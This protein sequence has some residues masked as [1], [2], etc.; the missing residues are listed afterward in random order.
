MSRTVDV[1][2]E[3]QRLI[4]DV[5]WSKEK[6]FRDRH[7]N[8]IAFANGEACQFCTVGA[9]IKANGEGY[10]DGRFYQSGP[11]RA[12]IKAGGFSIHTEIYQF[13]D[14]ATDRSQIVELFDE[15]IRI[16]QSEDL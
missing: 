13:N 12:L 9:V 6:F 10:Q 1:L 15:A 3:A 14:R 16:A 11:I 2:R 5:G 7:S 4:R 8:G